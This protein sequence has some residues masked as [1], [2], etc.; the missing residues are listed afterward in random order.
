MCS[1][2]LGTTNK[3]GACLVTS[4]TVDDGNMKH[5]L[6]VIVLGTE[7]S[8]ERG[9]VS[10]LLAKYALQVFDTGMEETKNEALPQNLPTHA[11][12]AV[13]WILRTA[14]TKQ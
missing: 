6:I 10:E 9:R 3:S 13:D 4:L 7:D 1:S 2:D 11:G 5:D 12:A 8:I 14:R